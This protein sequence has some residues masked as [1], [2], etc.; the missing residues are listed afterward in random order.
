[1]SEVFRAL[2]GIP[3]YHEPQP[4]CVNETLKN[5]NERT[6]ESNATR[7]EL[8]GKINQIID[9][10]Y[11]GW[12][13]ESSQMFIKAYYSE[14]LLHFNKIGVIYVERNPLDLLLSYAKKCR[15]LEGGWFLRS[16]WRDNILRTKEELPFHENILWQQLEVRERYKNIKNI[17][18]KHMS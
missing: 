2:T 18:T 17:S 8:A 4:W 15:Q 12:Y 1:M 16:N 10:I 3:S 14:V 11:N 6:L 9:S 7:V 13:F 5:V